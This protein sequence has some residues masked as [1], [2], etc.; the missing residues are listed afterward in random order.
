MLEKFKLPDGY[1]YA[2]NL[3]V[4]RISKTFFF[5]LIVLNIN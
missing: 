4:I 3:A 1:T 5:I 2:V